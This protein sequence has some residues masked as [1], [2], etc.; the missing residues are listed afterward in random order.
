MSD[1]QLPVGSDERSDADLAHPNTQALAPCAPGK[2][3]KIFLLLLILL[4]FALVF[5]LYTHIDGHITKISDSTEVIIIVG[6]IISIII[7]SAFVIKIYN[8]QYST[9]SVAIPPEDRKLLEYLIREEKPK[10]VELYIQVASLKGPTKAATTLGLTGLPLATI[11]LTI[12]FSIIAL[13]EKNQNFLD[14]AK[15]TLGAFIGSF[16]QR[17]N[18]AI[19]RAVRASAATPAPAAGTAAAGAPSSSVPTAG[20]PTPPDSTSGNPTVTAA[21]NPH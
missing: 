8:K 12:F 1:N 15:L 6:I 11:G 21:D 5:V 9:P 18:E 17:S 13:F 2:F 4:D 14:L 7:V 16:V 20:L 10:G 19:E 3:F